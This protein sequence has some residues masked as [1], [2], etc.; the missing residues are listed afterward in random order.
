MKDIDL[1]S[2]KG[3]NEREERMI[4][5]RGSDGREKVISPKGG[6]RREAQSNE[7]SLKSG[8]DGESLCIPIQETGMEGYHI[9]RIETII[10]NTPCD[11][12]I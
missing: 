5:V 3:M 9:A 7:K 6:A 1:L 10:L 11:P 12:T 2:L 4:R 8:E